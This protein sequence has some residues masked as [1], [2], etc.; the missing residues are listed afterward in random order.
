M[1]VESFLETKILSSLY[2]PVI[3]QRVGGGGGH[4]SSWWESGWGGNY[5][6]VHSQVETLFFF[7]L[8]SEIH[9]NLRLRSCR[10]WWGHL[11]WRRHYSRRNS[12]WRGLDGRTCS[13]NWPVWNVAIKLCGENIIQGQVLLCCWTKDGCVTM[14]LRDCMK[15]SWWHLAAY[16][17]NSI[18][19]SLRS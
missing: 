3:T 7:F 13:K 12:Y 6:L 15:S 5:L 8:H 14:K 4:C 11:Q 18:L 1:S 17:Q 9:C 2:L 10:W 16:D 19:S